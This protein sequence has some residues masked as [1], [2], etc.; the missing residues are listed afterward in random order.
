M[1]WGFYSKVAE[2]EAGSVLP[3]IEEAYLTATLPDPPTPPWL[4][5]PGVPL[6]QPLPPAPPVEVTL[7]A[8]SVR[9]LPT[10]LI[11]PPA[12]P[13]PPPAYS[14]PAS[15]PLVAL[16][17]A[18][19]VLEIVPETATESA[20]MEMMPPPAP[21]APPAGAKAGVESP[22]PPPPAPAA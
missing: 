12:P 13:P 6:S 10:I 15:Q 9:L 11:E 22:P 21:P 3:L 17:P 1:A 2:V 8:P 18:T 16:T 4:V 5:A 19:A 7:D 14:P 20:E